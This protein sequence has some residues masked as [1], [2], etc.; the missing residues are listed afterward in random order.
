M[1]A[2]VASSENR[3]ARLAE[4]LVAA[5]G[6][7]LI[8]FAVIADRAWLDRH[9]L[10]HMFL[11]RSEQILW[12]MVERALAV[13]LGL[14]LLLPIRAYVGRGFRMGRG[15]EMTVNGFALLFA[16][17]AALAVSEFALRTGNWGRIERWIQSEEPLRRADARLGWVNI[18][19]RVG[20][21]NFGGRTISYA[22]DRDGR[23]VDS[24]TRTIDPRRP[25]ILFVGESMMF[26]FRLNWPE[27]AAARIEE[28]TG[29]QSVNLSVNGYGTD[30]ELMRL[31]DELP[32]FAHP[33]AVVALFAPTLLE[34]SLDTHRP[35]LDAALQW[36]P[37]RPAWRLERVMKN[38]LLYHSTSRIDAGLAMTHATL[39]AIVADARARNATP[40]ILIP[41]F[42]PELPVERSLRE[43]AVGDLP[44]VRVQLDPSWSIPGDGHPD[45]RANA[46]MS[47]AVAAVLKGKHS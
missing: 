19:D 11:Q 20:T 34:R 1:A 3:Q 9:L 30:Q 8:L 16:V 17:M 46:A 38:V 25:S 27:T 7:A 41:E 42:G 40:I 37:A 13:L 21:D 45:A 12:W 4:L 24:L 36:H 32:R 47:Q 33:D 39:A 22:L 18:P 43:R 23:R 35:H 5:A 15:R 10:P 29:L 28:A 14:A 31:Q 44:F 6:L 26:G 2:G